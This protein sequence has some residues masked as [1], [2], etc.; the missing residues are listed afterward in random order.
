[1]AWDICYLNK[2]LKVII[3]P[4]NLYLFCTLFVCFILIAQYND[5]MSFSNKNKGYFHRANNSTQTYGVSHAQ[6]QFPC[7]I[8]TV[9]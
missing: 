1:M 8:L 3:D 2:L 4:G 5:L 7:V 6:I 9:G